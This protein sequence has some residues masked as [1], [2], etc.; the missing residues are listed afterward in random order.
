MTF[1]LLFGQVFDLIQ[2]RIQLQ[3]N[4]A[5]SVLSKPA[6]NV[7]QDLT[8]SV[9]G[10]FAQPS[11][12]RDE[13]NQGE[14]VDPAR[15]G[16]SRDMFPDNL[17]PVLHELPR[18]DVLIEPAGLQDFVNQ[19]FDGIAAFRRGWYVRNLEMKSLPINL[20][21]SPPERCSP[22]YGHCGYVTIPIPLIYSLLFLRPSLAHLSVCSW[23]W[24]FFE[25]HEI[26]FDI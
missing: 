8:L 20:P 6:L 10:K 25:C 15:A 2:I 12:I 23:Y 13:D 18:P 14:P 11:R 19:F 9:S 7:L 22:L 24:S 3:S 21:E 16:I 17:P 4:R 26:V 5:D 1:S